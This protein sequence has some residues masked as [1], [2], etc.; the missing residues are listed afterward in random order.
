MSDIT[1]VYVRTGDVASI[2]DRLEGSGADVVTG[3]DNPEVAALFYIARINSKL[4]NLGQLRHLY[5]LEKDLD[6]IADALEEKRKQDF[7]KSMQQN[8]VNQQ[9]MFA[10]DSLT[11]AAK[12]PKIF[13]EAQIAVFPFRFV[14]EFYKTNANL[15]D[16]LY[17][18]YFPYTYL[19][20]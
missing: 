6:R 9:K 18:E 15:S 5:R 20:S 7:L 14:L 19:D 4:D 16:E 2:L 17:E 1:T 11:S 13:T 8:L 3:E 12:K 10:Y